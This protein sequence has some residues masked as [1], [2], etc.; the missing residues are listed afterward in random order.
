MDDTKETLTFRQKTD[1]HINSQR[2]WHHAQGLC[3]LNPAMRRENGHILG[4]YLKLIPVG[5]EK[6]I[7]SSGVSL[8][9]LTILK[10]RL[11]LLGGGVTFL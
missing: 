1:I 5:K 8:G 11:H 7:F 4:S 3:R 10:S 2:L 6:L 9:I